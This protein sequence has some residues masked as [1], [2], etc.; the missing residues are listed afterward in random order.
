MGIEVTCVVNAVAGRLQVGL[1]NKLVPV[2]APFDVL[3]VSSASFSV[4]VII[5]HQGR[6][7][8]KLFCNI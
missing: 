1:A 6:P 3:Y 8:S 7:N 4:S 5:C 2:C